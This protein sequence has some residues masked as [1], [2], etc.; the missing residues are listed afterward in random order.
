VRR[1]RDRADVRG[2]IRVGALAWREAYDDV[3]SAAALDRV[4]PDPPAEVVRKRSET[5]RGERGETLVA[6][7][8]GAVRGYAF[9]R[10]GDGTKDFVGDDEAG[11]KEL[12]VEPDYWGR[13]IGTSLLEGGLELLPES[14]RRVKLEAL[15]GNDIGCGFYESRGFERVDAAEWEVDG[16]SYR[17]IVYER[18][19]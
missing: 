9:F 18:A 5:L 17:T 11:L 16:E 10:W 2:V 1:L 15:A 13:G 12:Y 14:T 7:V 4:R 8:D 6:E 19:L 3:L